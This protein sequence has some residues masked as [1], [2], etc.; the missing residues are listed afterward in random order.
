LL[1]WG[2][3]GMSIFARRLEERKPLSVNLELVRDGTEMTGLFE[4]LRYG[5]RP[6]CKSSG[7]TIVV[8]VT[9]ALGIGATTTV[10]SDAARKRPHCDIFR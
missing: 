5:L 6:L 2:C 7:F 10:F 3:R 8:V 1:S 9:L 4:D